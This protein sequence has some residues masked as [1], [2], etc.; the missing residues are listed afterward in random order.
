M[1]VKESKMLQLQPTSRTICGDSSNPIQQQDK[2]IYGNRTG[3]IWG[4]E[5]SLFLTLQF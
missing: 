3:F 5:A 2:V 4:G 1:L